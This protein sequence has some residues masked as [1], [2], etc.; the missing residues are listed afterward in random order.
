M[1]L[2]MKDSMTRRV[3]KKALDTL[4][5]VATPAE[6]AE[7]IAGAGKTDLGRVW[8]GWFAPMLE[9][10]D[11]ATRDKV[12]AKIKD[13]YG[14]ELGKSKAEGVT[15]E[16]DTLT[17]GGENDDEKKEDDREK[18]KPGVDIS[19]HKV[20]DEMRRWRGQDH[21]R[22]ATMQQANSDYWKRK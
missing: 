11:Q 13:E 4:L 14:N 12:L 2:A 17:F 16:L 7:Y 8:D 20:G 1:R 6:L 10:M 3:S 22:I 21:D 9:A 5:N 15:N 18:E 19:G